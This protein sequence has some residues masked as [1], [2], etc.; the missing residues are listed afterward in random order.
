MM[1]AW[2][3]GAIGIGLSRAA[4]LGLGAPAD[5]RLRLEL[6]AALQA[7]RDR[8]IQAGTALHTGV[9]TDCTPC[10]GLA[11]PVELLLAA[12]NVF[13]L[14]EHGRAARQVAALIVEQGAGGSWPC[15]I[16]GAGEMRGL[17][18]GRAGVALTL[19]RA[20]G[21]RGIASPLLPGTLG[22]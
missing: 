14:P 10:H 12:E 18:T 5:P 21:F 11:G 9:R 16:V 2:C 8:V 19:L 6:S 4:M 17:M 22:W 20:E 13:G 7:V 1:S 15:G 3:H